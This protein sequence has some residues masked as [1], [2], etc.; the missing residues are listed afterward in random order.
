MIHAHVG[1]GIVKPV[2]NEKVVEMIEHHHDH[3]DGS[4]L[5]QVVVGEDIPLA[6]RI[7]AVTDAFDAMTSDRPYRSAM[8]TEEALDE[9]RRCTGTQF[10]PVVVTA[11]LT[12]PVAE[13]VLAQMSQTHKKKILIVDDE[14]SVRR[15]LRKTLSKNYIVLEAED[16]EEAVNM[17]RKE[18]PALVLMDLMM[19]KMDG[20]TACHVIKTDPVTKVIRVVMLTVVDHELNVK[21]GREMGADGY[22]TKPFRSQELLDSVNS[23]LPSETSH[24]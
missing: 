19:P 20:Y 17:A 7:L 11:L 14:P 2:V 15:T 22:I 3:Y 24:A 23:F 6:A 16:G 13:I 9:I 21:L 10:D 5:N 12:I 8:S 18:K 1:A 4:G